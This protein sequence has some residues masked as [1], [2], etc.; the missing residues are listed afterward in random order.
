[1]TNAL[2]NSL[3]IIP[4]KT[5]N[6]AE[7]M[8]KTEGIDFGKI[9][10]KKTSNRE[11]ISDK[12][13]QV[14]NPTSSVNQDYPKQTI[15]DVK[16]ADSV[17]DNTDFSTTDNISVNTTVQENTDIVEDTEQN[18]L[19]NGIVSNTEEQGSDDTESLSALITDEELNILEELI[20]EEEDEELE[21]EI[22]TI[23]DEEPTMYNELNTLDNPTAALLLHSQIQKA[24]TNNVDNEQ[25]QISSGEEGLNLKSNDG[26]LNNCNNDTAIFKQFDNTSTKDAS[27][28]SVAAKGNS[29]TK[30]ASSK[31]S[32]AISENIVKELNVEVVSAQ[33]SEAEASMSDLM[34]NQSPQEQTARVMIQG[35]IKYES[36]A[37]EA[38]KNTV[39]TKMADVT[40]SKIIEQISKQMEGMFNNSKLTMILNPGS[41]GK[42]NLQLVNSKEGLM[43]QFTVTTQDAKEMLMKGL[44]GL[45]ESLL[46][47]GVN[48]DSVSVKLEET[49]GEYNLDYTE[50]EGSRGGN[51]H[52]GARK[53]KEGEKSFEQMMFDIENEGN[54]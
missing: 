2:I 16:S 46:A 13:S 33:S 50:Q 38:A 20:I 32:N 41:L 11:T 37:S 35:D 21:E 14:S 6:L 52:Q 7:K 43:A 51:K 26:N 45:K 19:L 53:Q 1:M 44:E 49:D 24:V 29:H 27:L 5:V 39:H 10:E 40:P 31:A 28:I 15:A 23:T 18:S 30:D 22:T 42:V 25:S 4:E 47:Q 17:S 36:V 12:T 34:Q 54:V 48:V 9:F 8:P 3:N